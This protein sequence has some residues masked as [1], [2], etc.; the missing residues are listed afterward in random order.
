MAVRLPASLGVKAG[1]EMR[2]RE[3]QGRY[4]VEPVE[5]EAKRKIDLTG[6]WG[7]CP[8]LRRSL[9]EE[10]EFEESERPW[11]LLERRRR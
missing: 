2:V 3:E 11:H 9:L 1:I 7:S 6:I 10:R 4:V 8:G 5:Q